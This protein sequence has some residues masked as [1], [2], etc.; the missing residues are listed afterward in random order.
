MDKFVILNGN[1]ANREFTIDRN[2]I[3]LGRDQTNDLC[4]S[5]K[6]VSRHHATVVKI[7][8]RYFLHDAGSTNGTRL[9]GIE[10]NKHILKNA[11]EIDIG[12]YKLRFLQG[13]G[14]EEG[15]D[16]EKTVVLHPRHFKSQPKHTIADPLPA[17]SATMPGRQ[18]RIRFLNGPE[19]GE[20]RSIDKAFFSIG[21]P[22]GNLVLINRRH[23]GYFLLKMG[24]EAPPLVNGEEVKA[25]GM[26]LQDGDRVRLG[27]LDFQFFL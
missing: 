19:E 25:G 17:P 15:D 22:G 27:E 16:L 11:D 2:E 10:I 20:E 1:T 26:E 6:S 3:S 13:N 14:A 7:S 5:D 24:G 12:K 9:N 23:T 21:K 8:N 4:L 18:A